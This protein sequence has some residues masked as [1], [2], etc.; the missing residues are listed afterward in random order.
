MS[1]IKRWDV[2]NIAQQINT[3]AYECASPYNDGFVGWGVKQDL[4]RIKWILEDALNR[5]P[6]YAPEDEWLREH[7]KQKVIKILKDDS[8]SR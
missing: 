7:E 6:H 4:Y 2:A 5:C 3:A 1:F 8:H